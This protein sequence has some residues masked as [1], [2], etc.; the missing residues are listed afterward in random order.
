LVQRGRP[1]RRSAWQ[2]APSAPRAFAVARVT[3]LARLLDSSD[4]QLLVVDH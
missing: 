2:F 3:R 1:P 4:Q